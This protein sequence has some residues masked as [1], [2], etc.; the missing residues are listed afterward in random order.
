MYKALFL[1]FFGLKAG[2]GIDAQYWAG[3]EGGL[4]FGAEVKAGFDAIASLSAFAEGTIIEAAG[5]L[6]LTNNGYH[7]DSGFRLTIGKLVVG[8]RGVLFKSDK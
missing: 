7:K 4:V 6:V 5:K 8:I 3:L 2:S 1:F